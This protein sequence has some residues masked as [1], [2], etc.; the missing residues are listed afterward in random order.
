MAEFTYEAMKKSGGKVRGVLNAKSEPEAIMLLRMM[1]LLN[2][3][4]KGGKSS[5]QAAANPL[6][7]GLPKFKLPGGRVSDAE[8]AVFT[9]QLSV[10]VDAGVSIVQALNLLSAA[11]GTPVLREAIILTRENV[12]GGIELGSAMEKSPKVFD[13]LYV[14]LIRAGTASGQLDMMLKRLS[15]YIEKASK[16]R[17]QLKSALTYPVAILGLAAIMTTVMLVFVVPMFAKNYEGTGRALPGLTQLVIDASDFLQHNF[18]YIIA[19]FIAIGTIFKKWRASP[20]GARQWDALILKL[21]IFGPLISKVCIARFASTMAT[22]IVSGISIIE[23]LEVCAKAAGNYV[24]Q[25]EIMKIREEVAQGKGIAVPL[26]RSKYFPQMVSSMISIGE[27]SGRLDQML[28]KIAVFFEEEVDAAMAA[29]LKM[30]EPAMFVLIGGIV[31]FILIAMY[32]PVFDM[33]NT[34]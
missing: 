13:K 29:A 19:V 27:Q 2:P 4:I 14:S 6:F 17:K 34:M 10:I 30:I 33:A 7:K 18:M 24:L 31:G 8:L 26:S 23:A 5:A 20:K 32:L 25:E 28:E 11:A 1:G 3:K 16:L 15:T 12:E 9:K 21:P 22:L